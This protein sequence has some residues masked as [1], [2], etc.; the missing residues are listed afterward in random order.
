MNKFFL[1]SILALVAVSV[2]ACAAA[3]PSPTPQT[4]PTVAAVKASSKIIAEGKVVPA[5]NA[6]LGFQMG[7]VVTQVAGAVGAPVKASQVL[8]QLDSKN[9][10]LLLAQAD[11]NLAV[12]QARLNQV[13]RG[14]T[15]DDLA[16]AQQAIKAAQAAYDKLLKPDPNDL[17]NAK[18]D[19]DRAQARVRSAQ[20]A[21]DAVGGDGNPSAGMLPQRLALQNAY[22]DW[23]QAQAA[24]NRVATSSDAAVQQALA[25][26]QIAK[27]QQSKLNPTAED[28]AAAAANVQAAQAARNLAADQL[29]KTK[30][31]A[32]FDGT[33]ASIDIN[34]GEPAIAGA[35]IMRL[36]D[37]SNMQIETTDLT[38]INV[39]NVNV[40]DAATVTVDALP[41]LELA[42]KITSIKGY[43][44][45]RQGDIVYTLVITLAQQDPRLRWNMTAKVSLNK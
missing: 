35:P 43:G 2:I 28:I 41:G 6:S 15:A 21:Y 24:Y 13:K 9:L 39:V 30:L 14:P 18:I 22:L 34:P 37:L 45:N 19:L 36:A 10:E 4:V 17:A 44:D 12:A 33:L 20:A 42:G 3:A 5:Q 11:A 29:N 8:A 16:A 31:V 32:P 27:D 25:A 23:Q 7:G 1:I 26:L 38:E 40:G